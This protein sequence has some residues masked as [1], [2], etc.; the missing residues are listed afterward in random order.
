MAYR[1]QTETFTQ[2]NT[3]LDRFIGDRS[4]KRFERIRV[5]TVGD[6]LRHVPRRYL[7]GIGDSDLTSLEVGED[8][9]VLAQVHKINIVGAEPR[10]RLE[11]VLTDGRGFL[12]ATFFGKAQLLTYWNKA[13]GT[14]DDRRTGIFV[15]KVKEFNGRPQMAHPK[16]VM[17]GPKG[18][19]TGKE[20]MQDMVEAVSRS[21]LIGFYPQSKSLPTWT[22]SGTVQFVLEQ[23]GDL[24][25]PMPQWV[26]DELDLPG[27][28][29][30]WHDV[31][32][33]ETRQRVD[34]GLERLRFD[35][36]LALQLTMAY[37]RA[38]TAHAAA[39][40]MQGRDD[41][42][43]AALD[44]RLPFALTEG[45]HQVSA[46][47]FDDLA[48]PHPMMRLLQG[49]VGSGKTVVALRAMARAIDSGHQ[50][51]LLAPTEV[52]AAQHLE[53]LRELLGDLGGGRTLGA[54]DQATE[55]VLLTGSM[56]AGAKKAAMLKAASGEA[57]IV[58]GTHAV[59]ADRVQFASLG[60][61]V[62]D[63]QH[64]FGVEQRSALNDKA[65][66]RPH[67]LVMTATPIPRTVAMTAFGDLE[68]STL[69][70]VPAGRSEVQTTIVNPS[71][72]PAWLDR[73]WQR[74]REEVDA[75]RQAFVVCSRISTSQT[76]A[77]AEFESD[78]GMPPAVTV[79]D[80]AEHLAT[81]PLAGLRLAP[82]HGRMSA[83]DKDEV[84]TA[85]AAGSID[86]V[87]ATTVVEV[88]VNVPNASVMVVMDADR[89][90]VS[91][92]HQLRGRI[93]RGAHPGLCLL[94]S[95]APAGKAAA[96]RLKAVASTRDGFVLAD[97]DL[98]ARRE[99]NILGSAQA[100]T[101][102]TLRLLRVLEHAETIG[103][104]RDIA[105]R[106]VADDPE[107]RNPYLADM[108]A[109]TELLAA[110][111]WLEKA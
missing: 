30:A 61:V 101:R 7:S 79:E 57:G 85:F 106:L 64:R 74:V 8:A 84:M 20:D 49:E 77:E 94:V 96:D 65:E 88:G 34:N 99:G 72:N 1:W 40:A 39:W 35:E 19:I 52:L 16:F 76:D 73:A 12:N 48:R 50:A 31:H 47:L 37:R 78:E 80:L 70:E 95:H 71:T 10:R 108:V 97:A 107:R 110:G 75:G 44:A 53:S 55:V 103:I 45:Q 98:E 62:I 69:R 66:L 4:A 24:T 6:L 15:G 63:E 68:T 23:L 51:V 67:T 105:E 59:L 9:A 109:Q 43:L 22:I 81:G 18:A 89:F 41:G 32:L 104:A 100:G 90:G 26:L 13:L 93:G 36:A 54:P 86:V 28:V 56:N 60:L 46:E 102:S 87:V 38:D 33:P 83:A 25:D 92:L 14:E 17:I 29:D 2:L 11:V 91:Q 21:G 82:L 27:M 58:V 111:D 42:L 3:P 5:Q